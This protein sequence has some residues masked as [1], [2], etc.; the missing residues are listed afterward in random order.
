M[1]CIRILPETW[2]RTLWPVGSSTRNVALGSVS[3]TVPST[4]I[5]CFFGIGTFPG[6]RLSDEVRH[7][8]TVATRLA[9]ANRVEQLNDN[10]R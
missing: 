9:R 10:D 1:K 8:H 7:D 6:Q 5:A 4:S 3:A 2:A